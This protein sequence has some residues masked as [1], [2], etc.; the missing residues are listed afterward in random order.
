[1]LYGGR[2]SGKSWG[3]ARAL[4]IKGAQ[5]PLRVLC[6]REQQNSI[7]ES[8][9]R[10]LCDQIEALG[11]SSF[12]EIQRDKI[13]GPGGGGFFFEGIRNNVTKIKS[14]E[15]IDICWVEEAHKVSEES[16]MVLVP[17]IRKTDSEIWISFNPDLKTDYTYKNFV[18]NPPK[19]S[20]VVN[21]NWRDNPWFPNELMQEME[22]L[23]LK[24]FD[25]YLNVWEGKC[26]VLLAGAVYATEMRTCM[27]EGRITSVPY[28][29]VAPVSA[30][31]DLG[32][33]DQTTIWFRQK[34]GFEWHFIDCYQNNRKPWD[35]YMQVLQEK[36]YLY[37]R[38]WLP[39]DA[40]A[41]E[42][43]TGMSIEERARKRYPNAVKLVKR[44]S[45]ADGI[46]AARTIFGDC[47]F[48]EVKCADGIEALQNYRYEVVDAVYGSLSR[49]PV[50]DW[51]SHFADG[52]RYAAVSTK[53]SRSERIE[54]EVSRLARSAPLKKAAADDQFDEFGTFGAPAGGADDWMTV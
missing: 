37:D 49:V 36:G 44:L 50:H 21:V 29:K 5:S 3:I 10:L 33:A 24:D 48:D 54:A 43:G 47:W 14:Y 53:Q 31:F 26:R 2:G 39:H 35:H 18:L 20:I 13:I 42:K 41:K 25:A 12:Y 4:L 9:H 1:M 30:I 34:I 8:V 28:S 16:W 15:G 11:L 17:T 22:E 27:A 46:D 19:N 6:C 40:K 38:I 32:W 51:S 7:A 45:M 23:K 52:F